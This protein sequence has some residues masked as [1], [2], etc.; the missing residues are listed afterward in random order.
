MITK[1][2]MRG[3]ICSIVTPFAADGTIDMPAVRQLIDFLPARGVHGLMVC[4]RQVF[5]QRRVERRSS[6]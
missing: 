6:P 5:G 4:A 2:G 3:V 1:A